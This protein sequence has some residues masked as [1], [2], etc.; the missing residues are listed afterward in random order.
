MPAARLDGKVVLIT[1][2][3]GGIGAAAARRFASEGADLLLTDAHEQDLNGLAGELGAD[4]HAHDVRSEEEWKAVASWAVERHGRVDVLLNNAGIFLAAPLAQTTLAD[5]RRVMDVNVDGVFLGMREIAPMMVRAGCGS[6]IN[7]SSVAGLT[8]GPY[9]TA[10]SAS[11][12]AVRGMGKTVAKELAG[13]GVRVNSIHPGQIDTDMNTRQRER[14]P[15]LIDKLIRGIPMRRIGT[16]Q[17]IAQALV[18]LASDESLYMTG[19]ELTLDGG[20]T[21]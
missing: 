20:A 8:G 12:W 6:I 9:L 1:G 14:T 15:E 16:P 19:A 7:V 3:A 10:Y 4:G 5:F 18:F 11:K 17:E 21:A 2:A 13:S